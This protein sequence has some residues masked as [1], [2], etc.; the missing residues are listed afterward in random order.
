MAG[1]VGTSNLLTG[2]GRAR[3][4]RP[5]TAS[6]TVR[7]EKIRLGE[8]GDAVGDGEVARRPASIRD[9]QYLGADTRYL[10]ALDAGAELDRRPR[11]NLTTT[12]MDAP[13]CA[14]PRVQ[15]RG[16]ASTLLALAS[17]ARARGGPAMT[18]HD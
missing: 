18:Q 11:Q 1:F 13:G 17:R 7:P 4:A 12:S 10:V 5:R 16:A 3:G 2:R 14:G 8:P 6:F 15:L 9:V